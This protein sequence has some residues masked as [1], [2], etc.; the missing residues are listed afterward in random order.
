MPS[1]D[2][3][4]DPAEDKKRTEENDPEVYV[5]NGVL[6]TLLIAASA[7]APGVIMEACDEDE[8][9]KEDDEEDE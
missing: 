5:I 4:E 1:D 2:P 3:F 8:E 7:Q 9:E 6:H